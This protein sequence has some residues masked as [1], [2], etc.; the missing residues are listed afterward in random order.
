MDRRQ[1]TLSHDLGRLA[2][3]LRI[4]TCTQVKFSSW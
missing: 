1:Q 2:V 4:T 3:Q